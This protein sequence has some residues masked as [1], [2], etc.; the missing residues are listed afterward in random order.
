MSSVVICGAIDMSTLG[1]CTYTLTDSTG[2]KGP[3]NLPTTG[4]KEPGT[5]IANAGV[6][7]PSL[8]SLVG[9]LVGVLNAISPTKTYTG[10][11]SQF[12]GRYTISVNSGTFSLACSGTGPSA[13][14][15]GQSSTSTIAS[16]G[17]TY[18]S[19]YVPKYVIVPKY[20]GLYN[21]IQPLRV[22]GATKERVTSS[23]KFGAQRPTTVP[24]VARWDHQF[25][26]KYMVDDD[27][28]W[29]TPDVIT[30]MYSWESMWTDYG[31]GRAPLGICIADAFGNYEQFAFSLMDRDFSESVCKR[32][33]SSDDTKFTVSVKAR[34]WPTS[35]ANVSARKFNA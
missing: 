34:L 1:T 14:L 4:Y 30:N 29:S 17:T 23:G 22:S 2:T 9:Y 3:F 15:F 19:E 28:R 12:T 13:A 6:T 27:A 8:G 18:T 33:A 35:T 26:P 5:L 16:T 31:L 24:R 21:Y 25:E 7:S 11:W 32:R 10:S 20:P